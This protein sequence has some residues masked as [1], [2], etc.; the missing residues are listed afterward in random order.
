MEQKLDI[1]IREGRAFTMTTDLVSVGVNTEYPFVLLRN[2]SG[3]GHY[4][5]TTKFKWGIDSNSVRTV[6]RI[7]KNPTI[8]TVGTSV[9]I[10]NTLFASDAPSSYMLAYKSPTISDKG[11]LVQTGITPANSS[12]TGLNRYYYIEPGQDVL[13]TVENSS[14]NVSTIMDV[15]WMEKV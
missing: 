3:T 10:A 2:P 6:V 8:T 14:S 11:T 9:T 4:S 12:S 15:C 7:Y 5:E 1:A 13:V